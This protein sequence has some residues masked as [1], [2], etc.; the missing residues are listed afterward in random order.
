VR[1]MSA[2][3]CII[4]LNVIRAGFFEDEEDDE[5]HHYYVSIYNSQHPS[6]PL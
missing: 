1:K 4:T 5:H 3:P 2:K 6:W